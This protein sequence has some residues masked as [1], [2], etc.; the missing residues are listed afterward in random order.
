METKLSTQIPQYLEKNIKE[1][2]KIGIKFVGHTN[3]QADFDSCGLPLGVN[4]LLF[5][6]PE[7]KTLEEFDY[8]H[9]EVI[10]RKDS[11]LGLSVHI[12]EFESGV[13]ITIYYYY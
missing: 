3:T 11:E 1:I 4:I 12:E 10:I 9:I 2:E 6:L 7:H 13:W 5:K 8:K